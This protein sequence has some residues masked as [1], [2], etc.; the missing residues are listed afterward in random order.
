M[1]TVLYVYYIHL[2]FLCF[3]EGVSLFQ[4]LEVYR[5]TYIL[6]HCVCVCVCVYIYI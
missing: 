4:F 1:H 2:T 3:S 6:E 5:H